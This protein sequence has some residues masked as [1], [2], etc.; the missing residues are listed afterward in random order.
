[1][2]VFT[3]NQI[4]Q[5]ESGMI[6]NR[7]F[8]ALYHDSGV[9][10]FARGMVGTKNWNGIDFKGSGSLIEIDRPASSMGA[11]A[12]TLTL[13]LRSKLQDN[14]DVSI[15]P[16]VLSTI[17]NEKYRGRRFMRWVASFDPKTYEMIDHP[18]VDFDGKIESITLRSEDG[19]SFLE[20]VVQDG[21]I[22]MTS[23]G[24]SMANDSHH[25]LVSPS[26][27]FFAHSS[28]AG[29]VAIYWGQPVPPNTKTLSPLT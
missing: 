1:M 18:I 14:A 10:G 11:T 20:G 26:D 28:I 17:F 6:I 9:Y 8:V 24:W 22:D 19:V 16:S 12:T 29:Q 21:N 3:P 15:P 7:D 25:K 4:A 13:R 2:Q 27:T 5:L 23:R